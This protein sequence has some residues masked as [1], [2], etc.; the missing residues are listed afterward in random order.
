[1][2]FPMRQLHTEELPPA[3]FEIPDAPKA[4]FIR[5][6]LPPPE[7]A[8]L[9]VVGSR[10]VSQYGERSLQRLIEGLRGAPVSI[11]SGLAWGTDA[12]AH[13]AAL[14][15]GLH[16][17]AVLPS[18]LDD[19]ALYPA[20]NR[21]LAKRILE[22]GGALISEN[23][24]LWKPMQHSFAQRNRIMAALS[25]ATLIIEASERSGTLIT[26]RLALEYNRE[27][28]AIPHEIG[29]ENGAGSNRLLREGAT[30]VRNSDDLLEALGLPR[31]DTT[32]PTKQT[33]P[34]DLSTPEQTVWLAL[35]EPLERDDLI[36]KTELSAQVVNIALSSLSIRGLVRERVGKIERS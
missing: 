4:L 3:L 32:L 10:R 2:P 33:L 31:R 36:Y 28:L 12:L 24:P 16:T 21:T 26:A 17:T 22:R 8:F 18:G 6:A 29:R 34:P 19:S 9:C 30:L 5:G 7:Y 15:T 13:S 11:V 23:P 25:R 20:M 35:E 27:V 14:E 1:M